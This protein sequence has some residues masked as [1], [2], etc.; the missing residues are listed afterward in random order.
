MNRLHL[1]HALRQVLGQQ[2]YVGER[3]SLRILGRLSDRGQVSHSPISCLIDRKF[4][5]F[6]LIGKGHDARS[7][8]HRLNISHKTVDA[9]R[10]HIKD[11]LKVASGIELICYAVRWMETQRTEDFGSPSKS[12]F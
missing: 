3:M 10:G 5:I 8:A 7:I 1:R 2:V 6:Q 11:K 12:P 9:H 4:E